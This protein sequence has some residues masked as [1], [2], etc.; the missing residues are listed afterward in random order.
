M[1][2]RGIGLCSATGVAC[3]RLAN[4]LSL[5]AAETLKLFGLHSNLST[6]ADLARHPLDERHT[7]RVQRLVD[8]SG[9]GLR[10]VDFEAGLLDHLCLLALVALAEILD[11][12]GLH[13]EFDPIERDEPND[14][15]KAA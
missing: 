8:R 15:L 3:Q 14:V 7:I 1:G 9:A 5:Y 2:Y 12:G 4:A 13:G 6:E 10:T 11:D